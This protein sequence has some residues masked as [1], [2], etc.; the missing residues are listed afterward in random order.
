MKSIIFIC[1]G[2]ICRSPMAH[3]YMQKR[4][5]D[6]KKSE[7]YLISSCG[8]NTYGG[9]RATQN[10]IQAIAK[11]GVN[12]EN[13]RSTNISD[14][15]LSTYDLIICMT[16]NHKDIVLFTYPNIKDKIFTLKEY[17]YNDQIYTDIDDPWGYDISVYN[18]CGKE[19]VDCVDKLIEKF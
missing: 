7:E 13:H 15:D 11:Y 4:I 10:A 2:N 18:S 1:T 8:T 9:E 16:E 14:V 3:W 5:D 19:I 12:M 6:M 17:V